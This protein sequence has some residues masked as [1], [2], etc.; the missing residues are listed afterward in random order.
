MKENQPL[1][2]LVKDAEHNWDLSRLC[3]DLARAKTEYLLTERQQKISQKEYRCLCGLL[4]NYK[5]LELAE[6]LVV[7][8][9]GLRVEMSR[10]I[11]KYINKLIEDKTGN[12]VQMYWSIIPR[13][14]EKLG[15]RKKASPP[16]ISE[17]QRVKFNLSVDADLSKLSFIEE[18]LRQ[19]PENDFLNIEKIE[20]GSLILVCET[21]KEGFE[22]LKQLHQVGEL[23][24]ILGVPILDLHPVTPT[25]NLTDWL[26]D[27]FTDTVANGWL[28]VTEIM[29]E[30]RLAFRNAAVKR[31]K[32]F[33]LGNNVKVALVID[34]V[35]EGDRS[36]NL[37]VYLYSLEPQYFPENLKLS[38][39]EE[40]GELLGEITATGNQ[41]YMEQEL[42]L[43]IGETVGVEISL[44]DVKVRESLI[45]P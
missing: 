25:V 38:F 42:T 32:E 39:L 36:F 18:L 14:L 31:A 1:K 8:G 7:E 30:R 3:E 20:R 27:N 17:S 34:V 15:Y 23:T 9:K 12:N 21:S 26:A 4:C 2:Q 6:I 5:P 24:E 28:T 35:P 43:E 37:L 22:W 11:Y 29:G 40:S 41:D 44:N 33:V 16:P 19:I 45:C 10:S 13:E